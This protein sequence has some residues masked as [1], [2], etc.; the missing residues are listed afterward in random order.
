M[1]F[2]L[3]QIIGAAAADAVTPVSQCPS[4]KTVYQTRRE[5]DRALVAINR[6]GDTRMRRYRCHFCW[7]YHLGHRRGVV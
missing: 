1:A 5:A 6:S 7:A 4:G 2:T 3:R